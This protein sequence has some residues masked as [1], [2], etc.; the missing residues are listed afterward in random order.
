MKSI[1]DKIRTN[2]APHLQ[3][4]E[5]VQAVFAAQTVSQYLFVPLLLLGIVPLVVMLAVSR[6]FRTVIVTDRRIL[7]AQAGRLRTTT[8]EKVLEEGPRTTRIGEPTGLWWV[9]TSLGN[10][11]LHVHKRFHKDIRD[12]DALLPAS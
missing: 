4:G 12:A 2:A 10:R 1:R 6:P 9:C 11:K 5:S 3:P 8:V 7:L